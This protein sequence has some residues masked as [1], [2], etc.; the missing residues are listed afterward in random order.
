MYYITIAMLFLD[1]VYLSLLCGLFGGGDMNGIAML[2]PQFP[3]KLAYAGLFAVNLAVF[4]KL[5]LPKY[6]RAFN[7]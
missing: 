6:R 5:V 7:E 4:F 3:A 2:I 1:P